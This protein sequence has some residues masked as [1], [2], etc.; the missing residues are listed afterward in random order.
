MERGKRFKPKQFFKFLREK[1]MSK[2]IDK[3]ATLTYD[4]KSYTKG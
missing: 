3:W 2:I 1:D 4:L